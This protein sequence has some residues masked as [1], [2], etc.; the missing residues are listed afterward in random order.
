M[1]ALPIPSNDERRTQ[2]RRIL[3]VQAE[4]LIAGR[5]PMSVR[6]MD[7][8]EGGLS[9][10]CA[11]N[12]PARTECTVRM[13]LPV[14]PTNRKAVELRAVVRY[15]VLSSSGGGFQLGMSVPVT[16]ESTCAAIKLYIKK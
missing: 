11:V 2:E 16:D 14:P 10:L 12:L 6:T 5:P 15:S 4:L 1:T 7:I 3:R 13:S 8:S 9:V